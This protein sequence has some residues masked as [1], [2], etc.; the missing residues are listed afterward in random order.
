MTCKRCGCTP[1]RPCAGGCAW[2]LP[3]LCSRCLTP[4]EAAIDHAY[5][6][7]IDGLRA[8]LEQDRFERYL[9]AVAQGL[10]ANPHVDP[11]DLRASGKREWFVTYAFALALGLSEA[12]APDVDDEADERPVPASRLVLE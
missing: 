9:L 11:H 7:M 10:A 1:E 6:S 12:A 8:E 3:D 4:E 2:T 5:A